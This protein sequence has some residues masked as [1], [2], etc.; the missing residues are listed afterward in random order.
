MTLIT[1]EDL[2]KQ[3]ELTQVDISTYSDE[4]LEL[5]L[6]NTINEIIGYTNL[7]INP[8]SH[9][10]IVRNFNS[11]L[12]E[13]DYYPIKEISSLRIGSK[14]LSDDDYIL[15]DTLG[16]LYFNTKGSGLLVVEYVSQLSNEFLS[17]NVTPLIV[18]IIRYR[19]SNDFSVDGVRTS[20]KEGD[21]SVNFDSS[22]S[23]GNLIQGRIANL[24]NN[25]Y[26]VRIKV[27]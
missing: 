13:L 26:S 17:V 22:S 5:L 10:Q 19:L 18:D 11:T 7:P 15:D 21:V 8:I 4:D 23:L 24:K 3:L 9:K 6:T 1:V 2:K 27:L 14:I 12:F 16:I 25:Y 20:I